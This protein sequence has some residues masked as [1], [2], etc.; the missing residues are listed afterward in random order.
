MNQS[1]KGLNK[2]RLW[3]SRIFNNPNQQ[4]SELFATRRDEHENKNTFLMTMLQKQEDDLKKQDDTMAEILN[5]L[6]EKESVI[7]ELE[8]KI[9]N[10]ENLTPKSMPDV[11]LSPRPP[12]PP[13]RSR[14]VCS[15][16]SSG[17][18]VVTKSLPGRASKTSP[19]I[20]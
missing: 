12:V 17:R 20:I 4:I 13:K 7:N 5:N 3:N 14:S 11:E 1:R 6:A 16:I 19:Y 2:R 10:L 18:T 9:R 15:N 8:S